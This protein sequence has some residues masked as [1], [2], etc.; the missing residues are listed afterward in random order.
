[1]SSGDRRART[2]ADADAERRRITRAAVGR[3]DRD[4]GHG[5]PRSGTRPCSTTRSPTRRPGQR[6]RTGSVRTRRT[7]SR[8]SDSRAAGSTGSRRWPAGP[9]VIPAAVPA[10]NR[11]CA[12]MRS[13]PGARRI[14]RSF[15]DSVPAA[16]PALAT[17]ATRAQ[18]ETGERVLGEREQAQDHRATAHQERQPKGP[19]RRS[20]PEQSADDRGRHQRGAGRQRREQDG[21]RGRQWSTLIA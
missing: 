5:G 16:A 21:E 1:M 6:S 10:T 20:S 8:T 15:A 7:G 19:R 3:P 18:D 17:I 11:P 13:A 4:P 9:A 2:A 14:S 12:R